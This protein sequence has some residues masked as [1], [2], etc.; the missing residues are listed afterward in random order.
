[1]TMG[2]FFINKKSCKTYE[3]CSK[4]I[5][6]FCPVGRLKSFSGSFWPPDLKFDIPAIEDRYSRHKRE[7]P[8]K[9]YIKQLCNRKSESLLWL[10]I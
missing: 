3:K 10:T 7:P 6:I 8:V 4:S 1:M 9:S 5:H 2:D